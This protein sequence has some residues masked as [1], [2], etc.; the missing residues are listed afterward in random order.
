MTPFRR[1]SRLL[2]AA[3][4]SLLTVAVAFAQDTSRQTSR[5]ERLEKEI[6]ILD[7]EIRAN[8]KR[9][10]SALNTLTLVQRKIELRRGLIEEGEAQIA[11]IEK[12]I[13]AKQKRLDSLQVR[14]DTMTFYYNR[15]VKGA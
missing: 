7:G 6:A 3:A 12:D 5:K 1:I 11:S 4:L 15:L 8:A 2:A 13:R 14:L 9:S 10:S